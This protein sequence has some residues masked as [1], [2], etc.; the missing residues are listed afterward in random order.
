MPPK[1]DKISP[2]AVRLEARLRQNKM[3]TAGEKI[4]VACSGGPDSVALF[5]VL[6]EL[7]PRWHLRLGLLHFDHG[8]RGAESRKDRDFVRALAKRAGVPYFAGSILGLRL[9][10]R[11]EKKSLEEAAREARYHFFCQAAREHRIPKIALAHTQDDQ[12]ET[13]L[14]RLV[15]GTGLRGLSGIRPVLKYGKLTLVRPL[16]SFPKEA[17]LDYLQQNRISSR[18]DAS[19]ERT[20][21]ERNKMRLLFLPWLKKEI[22]PRVSAALA[23]L[24]E[25][26]LQENDLLEG[27]AEKAYREVFQSRRGQTIFLK[28][29]ELINLPSA[30]GFRVIE[31]ALKR[32]DPSSGLGFE[33]WQTLQPHLK[34]QV[35]CQSLP[36][37]I[38]IRL[39]DSRILI[40]KKLL[41]RR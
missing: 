13:V 35:F 39:T 9:K 28:R 4:F 10:A 20:A 41:R 31:R 1:K 15:R 23:R 37:D 7:Q 18:R 40:Y 33:A 32:L 26:A 27:L 21:Y 2:L 11:R 38:D 17:L 30:L 24:P 8:L 25:I 19:N 34:K 14:M 29:A 16:L 6:Q 3:I 12:A 5:A 22:N 36:K